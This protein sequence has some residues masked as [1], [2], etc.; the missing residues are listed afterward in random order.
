LTQIWG[1][2]IK[3]SVAATLGLSEVVK[4]I[5]RCWTRYSVASYEVIAVKAP[6]YPTIQESPQESE[7]VWEA[8]TLLGAPIGSE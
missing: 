5:T 3:T 1:F 7:E 4:S 2:E 6:L 8:R